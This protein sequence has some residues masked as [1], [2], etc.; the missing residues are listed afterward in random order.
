MCRAGSGQLNVEGALRLA[1]LVRSDVSSATQ[2]GAPLL[3]TSTLP[4]PSTTLNSYTFPW[5]KGIVIDR[6]YAKGTSLISSYQKI[7]DLGVTI[8]DGVFI[9]TTMTAW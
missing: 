6:T 2:L 1:R 7:Y 4:V 8:G 9:A 5:S 3:T